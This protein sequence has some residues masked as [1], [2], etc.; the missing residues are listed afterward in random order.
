MCD[1]GGEV[2]LRPADIGVVALVIPGGKPVPTRNGRVV[3]Q[4]IAIGLDDEEDCS[5]IDGLGRRRIGGKYKGV[6]LAHEGG[7]TVADR[8]DDDNQ[9]RLRR[10]PGA[11]PLL[12]R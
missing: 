2:W 9:A 5:A 4:V 7:Q 12:E 3:N 11:R 8:T 10:P 6:A 1:S